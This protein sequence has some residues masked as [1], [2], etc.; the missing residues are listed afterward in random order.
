MGVKT[1]YVQIPVEELENLKDNLLED[2]DYL[3][4]NSFACVGIEMGNEEIE[5]L[6]M[7]LESYCSDNYE[8]E[9]F[10]DNEDEEDCGNDYEWEVECYDFGNLITYG[11]LELVNDIYLIQPD[12]VKKVGFFLSEF[13]DDIV[14]KVLN[15]YLAEDDNEDEKADNFDFIYEHF[16][17]LKDFIMNAASVGDG[18]AINYVL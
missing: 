9:N 18:I 15:E 8:D 6:F 1:A 2:D 5:Y 11:Q 7:G 10:A 16:Q 14:R 13:T 4:N 17:D 12:C 3:Y